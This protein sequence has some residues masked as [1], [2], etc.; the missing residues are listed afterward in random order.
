MRIQ[1]H[2]I[3][4]LG[5][6]QQRATVPI[7]YRF[8]S[9][10]NT[11]YFVTM[12]TFTLSSIIKR[13]ATKCAFDIFVIVTDASCQPPRFVPSRHSPHSRTMSTTNQLIL[14]AFVTEYS[15]VFAIYFVSAFV[16]N[17]F[18]NVLIKYNRIWILYTCPQTNFN[19]VLQIINDFILALLD[20]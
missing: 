6:E 15:S 16:E 11:M 12:F 3:I 4:D 9:A 8:I 18:G 7:E 19:L 13:A 5:L 14:C 20:C 1:S 2:I 17:I 10:M